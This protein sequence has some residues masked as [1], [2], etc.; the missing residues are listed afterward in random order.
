M[1]QKREGRPKVRP[2]SEDRRRSHMCHPLIIS[3]SEEEEE[4]EDDTT[5]TVDLGIIFLTFITFICVK[6][7]SLK[8]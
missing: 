2:R 6:G 4:E 8:I 7:L 1:I 5:T 3:D